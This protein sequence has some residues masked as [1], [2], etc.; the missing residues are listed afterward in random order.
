M[1]KINEYSRDG[2]VVVTFTD[3]F[4]RTNRRGLL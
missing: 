1:K 4:V 3:T 2:W